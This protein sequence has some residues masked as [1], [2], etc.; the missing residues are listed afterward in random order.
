MQLPL[1]E[2]VRRPCLFSTGTDDHGRK[3]FKQRAIRA[4]RRALADELT[5]AFEEM[6][7]R[8][9]CSHDDFIRTGVAPLRGGAGYLDRGC[10]QWRHLQGQLCRLV[11]G[12][13]RGLLY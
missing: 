13:G 11:F 9:S 8:L 4:K 10:R 3:C 7:R 6:A 2:I 1:P 5:P 12:A